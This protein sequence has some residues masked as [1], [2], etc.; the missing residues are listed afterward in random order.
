MTHAVEWKSGI[1]W[2]TPPVIDAGGPNKAPS[3]AIVLFDGTNMDAFHGGDKCP[4][5]DGA[6]TVGG[7]IT[8]KQEF[9]DV[10][11]HLE[12]ATPE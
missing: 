10:Q 11:L 4:I 12:F 8:T 1:E 9:G 5:A 7:G 2:Q 6:F 3:D